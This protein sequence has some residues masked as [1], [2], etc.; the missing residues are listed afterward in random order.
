MSRDI[1]RLEYLRRIHCVQDYIE[2]KIANP[3]TLEELAEVA[4]FSK[5]HFHRIFSGITGESLL[6]YVNRIKLERAAAALVQRTDLSVTDIAYQYGFTDSA[7]FSRAFK[8]YHAASPSEYRR[9]FRK[10]RKETE[11]SPTYNG[12]RSI[13]DADNDKRAVSGRIEILPVKDLR[14]IYMR[15]TGSYQG[16]A[17]AF[18]DLLS[19]LFGFA[20]RN[21]LFDPGKSAVLSIYHDNPG[22][23]KADHLRTSLC[24]TIPAD[25]AIPQDDEIG[26]MFIPSGDYAI[27]H[28]EIVPGEY[29]SAW[30]FMYREWLA[31]SHY[32]PRD[33]LP[34]ELYRSNPDINPGGKQ[35]VDIYLPVEPLII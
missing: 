5:F 19:K 23:T 6:H 18:P 17:A 14:V 22:F 21:S 11:E 35:Q 3:F 31:N 25:A 1:S 34:F 15:Y 30:D 26:N 16:L 4:G 24:L 8:N 12:N 2:S 7:I 33:S 20:G 13:R 32:Q 29:P 28:F 9:Q 27:G 10:N